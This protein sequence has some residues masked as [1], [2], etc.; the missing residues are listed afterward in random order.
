MSGAYLY[1]RA[2]LV[3]KEC[4]WNFVTGERQINHKFL[5]NNVAVLRFGVLYSSYFFSDSKTPLITKYR[6]CIRNLT[7]CLHLCSAVCFPLNRPFELYQTRKV[8]ACNLQE[9]TF[10]F[11]CSVSTWDY[12]SKWPVIH[13]VPYVTL[14]K[15][16]I[17]L[18]CMHDP[19]IALIFLIIFFT[20]YKCYLP[21]KASSDFFSERNYLICT[22]EVDCETSMP[23]TL[24]IVLT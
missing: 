17:L 23:Y 5:E 6:A 14:I 9:D 21:M 24:L 7:L 18:M 12:C 1:H 11:A 16:L 10:L 22:S 20:L 8:T 13:Y 3:F 4:L 19:F 2:M 15:I